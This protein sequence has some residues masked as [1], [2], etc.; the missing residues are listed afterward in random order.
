[1]QTFGIAFVVSALIC[2]LAW[3]RFS[4]A[5]LWKATVTP[6]ASIIG[7]GFLVL[8]PILT[9]AYGGWT[10]VMMGLL[11]L[12]AYAI[13]AAVRFN[14]TALAQ[15]DHGQATA[16]LET[17]SSWMLSFAYIIS[18]A[19]YLNLLG[20]F[21]VSLTPLN[22]GFAARCVTTAVFAVILIVGWTKGFSALE[23]L[24]QISV[25]LKLAII[26][27]LLFGLAWFFAG[28]MDQDALVF[29]SMQVSGLG[30]IGLI[31]GLLVTVQGFETSRY[32]GDS[33]DAQTR[34]RSM[35]LAQW[36]ST[37]IYMVYVALIAYV[38][39]PQQID[40]S[41]TAIIDMMGMVAPILPALLVL[42]A[43]AA[44]F[45][46]AVA[47]TSGA[48]GLIQE[49]TKGRVPIKLGYA[50]LVGCGI[51]LTWFMDVFQIISW[52][53]K[54]FALYYTLQAVIAVVLARRDGKSMKLVVF[55]GFVAVLAACAVLFGAAVE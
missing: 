8:G 45:S 34:V 41:E 46:A 44:Q 51:A 9:Q 49:L 50:V 6:L 11:C 35:R 42:A 30:G 53:S 55:Y 17:L 24:E 21:A 28:K 5:R 47:D 19:Y 23:R 39:A 15:R 13:G 4:H 31:L 10:P 3:P 2:I 32:L 22:T 26:G 54:A 12:L 36:I 25:T 20:S 16:H 27:G 7:S 33:Y 18:V 29:S 48:G 37:V 1:M 40:T 14:I 43:L 52:A 38:F